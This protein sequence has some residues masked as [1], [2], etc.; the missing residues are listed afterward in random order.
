MLADDSG[1][2]VDYLLGAP[3]VLSARF[4]GEGHDDAANNEKLLKAMSGVPA[5][6][7]A[8]QFVCCIALCRPGKQSLLARGK[9]D[10]IVTQEL[11][12]SGGFGYDPLFYIK[13]KQC[14]YA[15]LSA[16]EKNT[17]SHRAKALALLNE[18]LR[19]EKHD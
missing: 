6:N 11:S 8:C 15:Q 14:T 4:A 12:G 5:E 1:L 9:C 10:G 19:Q 3:G 16:Q 18:L 13:S 7:R 17:I 2:M